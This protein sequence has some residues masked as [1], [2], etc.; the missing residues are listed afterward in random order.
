MGSLGEDR[1]RY[2]LDPQPYNSCARNT[3]VIPLSETTPENSALAAGAE[4]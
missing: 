4:A 1:D 3:T 2:I